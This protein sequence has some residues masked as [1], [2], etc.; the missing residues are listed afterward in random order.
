[1]GTATWPSRIAAE[2]TAQQHARGAGLVDLLAQRLEHD[3]RRHVGAERGQDLGRGMVGGGDRDGGR[4]RRER[5]ASQRA[6]RRAQRR[7]RVA[8][9]DGQ[10][11]SPR[12]AQVVARPRPARAG[13]LAQGQARRARVERPGRRHGAAARLGADG[14]ALGRAAA[15]SPARRRRPR[16]RSRRPAARAPAATP[17]CRCPRRAARPTPTVPT[18]APPGARSRRCS[19]RTTRPAPSATEAGR[20]RAMARDQRA[21]HCTR[22]APA[23]P[24]RPSSARPA[25][26]PAAGAAS[27]P[28]PSPAS[29]T[30]VTAATTAAMPAAAHRA[31]VSGR[32]ARARRPSGAPSR[33]GDVGRG[34]D[35]RALPRAPAR[36]ADEGHERHR[37]APLGQR[38]RRQPGP[39]GRARGAVEQRAEDPRR[40]GDHVDGVQALA[41]RRAR[42]AHAP[43]RADRGDPRISRGHAQAISHPASAALAATSR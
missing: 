7:R 14:V 35:D 16:R 9:R 22:A 12:R 18:T 32:I 26:S 28:R 34:E 6:L 27:T 42:A 11:G 43:P 41:Q 40:D 31:R 30:S 37:R 19:P 5:G 15:Q 10:L 36:D 3:A 25:T 39:E 29:P 4:A 24:S 33:K 21:E 1:M 23:T 17:R 13:R 8:P 38:G 2:G 20:A